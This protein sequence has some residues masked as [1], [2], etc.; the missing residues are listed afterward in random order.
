MLKKKL[1]ILIIISLIILLIKVNFFLNISQIL[2][3]KYDE[4]ISNVYG[5][6]EREGIGYVKFLKKKFEINGKIDLINSLE[7]NNN[8][9]GKW[10][11]YNSNYHESEKSDYLIII[12]YKKI[13]NKVNLDN[14]KIIHN[15][16]DCY[17]LLKND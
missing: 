4:R 1:T 13:I 14:F 17:L 7:Q 3:V 8:N 11:I 15:H 16:Q 10:A 5:F 12:N 6:C 2:T 9:S